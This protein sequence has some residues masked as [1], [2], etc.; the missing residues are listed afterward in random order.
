[1]ADVALKPVQDSATVG[2]G[3]DFVTVIFRTELEMLRLQ[4]RSMARFLKPE[5][6]NSILIVLNDE[7]EEACQRGV[8]AMLAEWGHLAE[9]VQII[10][11]SSLLR[12]VK[13][14]VL[15][16]LERFWASGPRCAWRPYRDRIQ[17]KPRVVY[18][19]ARNNG[20]LMQQAFK[21]LAAYRATGDY[22]VILDAK[23]FFIRSTD[24]SE[25]VDADGRPRVE[26]ATQETNY[27]EWAE[28]SARRIGSAVP[29]RTS[30]PPSLT[31]I[32]HRREDMVRA[33]G[34][35]EETLGALEC[36]FARRS[37]KSTEFMLLYA[38]MSPD[39]SDWMKAFSVR[40]DAPIYRI[41]N[42]EEVGAT[43]DAIAKEPRALLS[44]HR[45]YL[46]SLD[47]ETQERLLSYLREIGLVRDGEA[48]GGF[49]DV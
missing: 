47:A 15:A 14:G 27:L 5:D 19:W 31:P 45:K 35:L 36:F 26:P 41:L 4:A 10:A 29:Q 18:G 16:H 17:G 9:R 32:V 12:P 6:V 13:G 2:G 11:G 43:L 49:F 20:W 24:A 8:E 22:I 44:L 34:R 23:N 37:A 39:S 42:T 3:L 46:R 30:I 1:M 7:D 25:F 28:K 40:R 48:T 21:L 38:A 33:V